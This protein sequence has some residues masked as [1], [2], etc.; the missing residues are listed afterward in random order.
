MTEVRSSGPE[1]RTTPQVYEEGFELAKAIRRE[2]FGYVGKAA[3]WVAVAFFGFVG[4]VLWGYIEWRLPQI[5]GA[6]PKNGVLAFHTEDCPKRWEPL[7]GGAMRVI[8]GAAAKAE[9]NDDIHPRQLYFNEQ[10]G[11]FEEY[12]LLRA[13]HDDPP[14]RENE[15]HV[16]IPG[17]IAL[18]YCEKMHD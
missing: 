11:G 15:R 17:L 1:T 9:N 8:V 18:T 12:L 10:R 16:I 6:V 13:H 3:A 2:L 5:A 7:K 14:L 4:A